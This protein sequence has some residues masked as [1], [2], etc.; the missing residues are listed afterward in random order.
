[1]GPSGDQAR[2]VAH[3]MGLGLDELAVLA[4]GAHTPLVAGQTLTLEP[5]LVLPG[6]GAVGVENV[7]AMAEGGGDKLP[8]LGDDVVRV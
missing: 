8:V 6:I 2:F 7:W 3:G 1:M 5:K 4:P